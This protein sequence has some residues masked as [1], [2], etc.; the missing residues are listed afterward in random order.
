MM[1]A[2]QRCSWLVQAFTGGPQGRR[3]TFAGQ[4]RQ[5][6][7]SRRSSWRVPALINSTQDLLRAFSTVSEGCCRPLQTAPD[8]GAQRVTGA[9]WPAMEASTCPRVS[10]AALRPP[11][12]CRRARGGVVVAPPAPPPRRRDSLVCDS[13]GISCETLFQLPRFGDTL[14]WQCLGRLSSPVLAALH[15]CSGYLPAG[16]LVEHLK[17]EFAAENSIEMLMT[18]DADDGAQWG[19]VN[20]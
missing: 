8:A 15:E 5:D 14:H 12:R 11:R 9:P 20:Y 19:Q 3:S 2:V 16:G 4:G 13:P 18:P 1:P 7:R 6:R 10:A 17:A